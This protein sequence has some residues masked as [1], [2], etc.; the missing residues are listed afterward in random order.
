MNRFKQTENEIKQI[1]KKNK[2]KIDKSNQTILKMHIENDNDFL[3]PFSNNKNPIISNETAEFIDNIT[4]NKL[5]SQS[6]T[7]E[8]TGD[9]VD[10]KEKQI[11][12]KAIKNYYIEKYLSNQRELKIN[13]MIAFVLAIFGVLVLSLSIFLELNFNLPIWARVIDIVGW[14][15]L[16]EATDIELLRNRHLKYKK[17]KYL[18]LIDMKV[19]FK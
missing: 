5:P 3:S 17:Y 11:Y 4:Q 9:C 14:V 6:L 18:S 12:P 10:N 19:I 15:L 7:L 16:W 1:E 8:I 2:Q 13:R